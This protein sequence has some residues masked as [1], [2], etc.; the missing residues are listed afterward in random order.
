MKEEEFYQILKRTEI[1]L[2]LDDIRDYKSIFLSLPKLKLELSLRENS[3]ELDKLSPLDLH[4]LGFT[5]LIKEKELLRYNLGIYQKIGAKVLTKSSYIYQY[6]SVEKNNF[7]IYG[8]NPPSEDEIHEKYKKLTMAICK[9]SRGRVD[10]DN[11]LEGKSNKV[12]YD[13]KYD[14]EFGSLTPEAQRL[15]QYLREVY[16]FDN[17]KTLN[18][19]FTKLPPLQWDSPNNQEELAALSAYLKKTYYKPLPL[20]IK[21]EPEN[22]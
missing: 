17:I 6:D 22:P 2:P 4:V 16:K 8:L 10:L 15:K 11:F 18:R 13:F 21:N 9:T 1:D 14:R 5:D 7:S 19:V 3:S 20:L 12:F